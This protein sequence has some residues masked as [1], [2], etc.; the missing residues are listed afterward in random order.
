M[1]THPFFH[2]LSLSLSRFFPAKSSENCDQS[3]V[4]CETVSLDDSKK[5]KIININQATSLDGPGNKFERKA[6]LIEIDK[7]L[8]NTQSGPKQNASSSRIGVWH[9]VSSI[10]LISFLPS[11]LHLYAFTQWKEKFLSFRLAL[12]E[13]CG[14]FKMK[15]CF[16]KKVF[17][18]L[19]NA[20]SVIS[21][22]FLF[23]RLYFPSRLTTRPTTK[24]YEASW[25]IQRDSS[26]VIDISCCWWK[27]IVVN[28]EENS[29]LVYCIRFRCRRKNHFRS[30]SAMTSRTRR[31][32]IASEKVNQF[33][34]NEVC[35][36]FWW[37][38][39]IKVHFNSDSWYHWL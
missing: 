2:F 38:R 6:Q 10:F 25:W 30:A 17:F 35:L 1:S 39:L 31:H 27:E 36:L 7:L 18:A 13:C 16:E 12:N 28:R 22:I 33:D 37:E 20:G 32:E 26:S 24:P 9:Q 8:I 15:I 21:L 3:G 34:F 19:L 29:S 5:F 11:F 4:E 23:L 14:A